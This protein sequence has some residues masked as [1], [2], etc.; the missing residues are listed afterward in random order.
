MTVQAIQS[1]SLTIVP[2]LDMPLSL[3]MEHGRFASLRPK[4]ISDPPCAQQ[5][6]LPG[7]TNPSNHVRFNL[8]Y[9]VDLN[10]S[11]GDCVYAAYSGTVINVRQS[12]NQGSITIDHHSTG[13]GYI[14]KYLHITN[15]QVAVGD[16]VLQGMPIAEVAGV[17][18]FP[19]LHFELWLVVDQVLFNQGN[20]S[21]NTMVPIDPTRWLYRWEREFLEEF[22]PFG[23]SQV[24]QQIAVIQD[25]RLPFFKVAFDSPPQTVADEP[26][27]A[28][29]PGSVDNPSIPAIP[30][31]YFIPL[32]EPVDGDERLMVDMLQDAFLNQRDVSIHYRNSTFF[33]RRIISQVIVT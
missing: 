25:N 3:R 20:A 24:P 26:G 12:G 17:L 13:F 27:T 2:P 22:V 15:M 33:D 1:N 28:L 6:T 21:P 5:V 14:T 30:V 19:H 23:G 9:G 11:P 31:S 29:P 4:P 32:Y 16:S 18:E 7:G 10:A 8:H